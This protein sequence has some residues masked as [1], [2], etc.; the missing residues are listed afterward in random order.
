[1]TAQIDTGTDTLLATLDAGVATLTMNRP[2]ARNAINDEL[3]EALRAMLP[4]LA[5]DARVRVLVLTG[6]GGAFSAGGDIRS[7][8]GRF[9][10]GEG[11]A[12]GVEA[13]IDT[14]RAAQESMLIPLYEFPKPTIAAVPGAAAGAAM[15]TALACDLRIAGQSAF[16]LPAFAGIGLSGDYGGSWLLSRLIGTARA[17]EAYFLNRRIGAEE[18]LALGAFNRVVADDALMEETARVARQIA[19][20]PP[21]ALRY[22]KENMNRAEHTDLRTAMRMEAD[23]MIRA[24]NTEDHAAAKIAFVQKQKPVFEGR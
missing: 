21:I 6:A 18:G 19:E 20:G 24:M 13:G 11:G 2:E 3:G 12:A 14:L 1:M 9:K 15:G 7:M 17:R 4:V 8:G 5:A 10:V 16:L 23:R 22:M